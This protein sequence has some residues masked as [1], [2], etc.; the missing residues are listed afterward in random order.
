MMIRPWLMYQPGADR[1]VQVHRPYRPV[2]AVQA[3]AAGKSW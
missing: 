2:Q 3:D 1:C